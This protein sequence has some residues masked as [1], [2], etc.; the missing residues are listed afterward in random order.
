MILEMEVL[1]LAL[2][3]RLWII[4]LTVSSPPLLSSDTLLPLDVSTLP[5]LIHNQH[6]NEKCDDKENHQ[7]DNTRPRHRTGSDSISMSL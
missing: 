2:S 4:E 6:Q 1:S 5:T 3:A 7:W